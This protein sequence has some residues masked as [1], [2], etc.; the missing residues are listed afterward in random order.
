MASEE[1]NLGEY[2]HKEY[3]SCNRKVS[4]PRPQSSPRMAALPAHTLTNLCR[5][6]LEE[7][8]QEFQVNHQ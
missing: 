4:P 8:I 2:L 1:S 3:K 7:V 6:G 5:E